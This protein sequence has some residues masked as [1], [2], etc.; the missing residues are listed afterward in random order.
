MK[1]VRDEVLRMVGIDP[2][3]SPW[4]LEN[5]S[6]KKRDGLYRVV[7]FAW[8]HQTR[9]YRSELAALCAKPVTLKR[10]EWALTALGVERAQ[11]LRKEHGDG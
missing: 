9:H 6:S 10:G 2:E 1:E 11:E 8:Y 3:N 5:T 4:P 7:H